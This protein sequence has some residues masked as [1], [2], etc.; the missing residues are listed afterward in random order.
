M[1]PLLTSPPGPL[2]QRARGSEERKL[3]GAEFTKR[4]YTCNDVFTIVIGAN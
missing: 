3:R 4:L 2:S 1:R